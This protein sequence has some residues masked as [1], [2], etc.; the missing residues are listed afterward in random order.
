M[1]FVSDKLAAAVLLR[2]KNAVASLISM[3]DNFK[4]DD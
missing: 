2:E 3:A 4:R 1:V